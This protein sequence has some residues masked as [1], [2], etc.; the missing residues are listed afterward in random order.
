MADQS[1]AVRRFGMTLIE[2]MVAVSIIGLICVLAVPSYIKARRWAQNTQFINNVKKCAEALDYYGLTH[3]DYPPD[4]GPGEMPTGFEEFL[5][6]HFEWEKTTSI[7]GV[8]DWD[9]APNRDDKLHGCYAGLSVW[10]PSRTSVQ[11][12]EVDNRFDDGNLA[13]G[14]FRARDEGYIYILEK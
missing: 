3:G 4:T 12:Q 2:L 13:T 5:P 14:S 7:G 9:R 1:H 8:W 11:M 6:R 10:R